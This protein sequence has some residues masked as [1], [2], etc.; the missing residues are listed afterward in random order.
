[1]IYLKKEILEMIYDESE[2]VVR[3]DEVE[4]LWNKQWESYEIEMKRTQ[5]FV[6][7]KMYRYMENGFFHDAHI[8]SILI[9]KKNNKRKPYY[10]LDIK[11][12]YKS[13]FITLRHHNINSFKTE[14]QLINEWFSLDYYVGEILFQNQ[15]LIHN[16]ILNDFSK[17]TE[18]NIVCQRIT[19]LEENVK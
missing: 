8:D 11:M 2:S 17:F 19:L 6:S 4:K 14:I 7:K 15:K 10:N 5:N 13:R 18:I 9:H 3:C 1:M 16:F 12:L